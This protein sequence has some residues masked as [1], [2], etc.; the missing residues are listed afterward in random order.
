MATSKPLSATDRFRAIGSALYRLT[1]G[2]FAPK[3]RDVI[4]LTTTGRRSGQQHT[5]LLQAFPDGPDMVLVAANSGRR[6]QPDWYHDLTANP[7]A[8]VQ[9]MDRVIPVRASTKTGDEAA[10]T[11]PRILQ[12]APS[13]GRY[14]RATTRAIPLIRL[15]PEA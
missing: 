4:T 12:V 7:S 6:A 11:W 8:T 3:D 14:V 13:H 15:T 9:L 5:V 1:K 2:R 10:S